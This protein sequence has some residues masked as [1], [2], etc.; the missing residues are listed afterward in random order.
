MDSTKV[1]ELR[2]VLT[3]DDL[4]AAL[5]LYRDVLGLT[6]VGS[7]SSPGG[8]VAILEAGR[9]TL[10]LADEAHAEAVDV[11][12]VGHRS[13][14]SVRLALRVQDVDAATEAVAAAGVE[15]LAAV[16]PTPWGS[17]N[18]R[19]AGLDGIQLTLFGT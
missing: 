7:V 1:S 14:G 11:A 19:F 6:E 12:E 17:R 15:R 5:H 13:A 10:E 18:A 9:A 4:A 8:R 2:V 16:T 3:T